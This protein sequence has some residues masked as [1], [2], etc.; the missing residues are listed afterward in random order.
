M[1]SKRVM[2]LVLVVPLAVGLVA[3]GKSKKS[4]SASSSAGAMSVSL[5]AKDFEFAPTALDVK[6]GQKV[7]VTFKNDGQAEHNFSITSLKVNQDLEAGK[8]ATVTFTAPDKA[9]DVEYFCEYHKASHNMV[10]TLH[11]T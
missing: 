11:V 5:T 6:A 9:G 2:A 1:L 7:T 4:S 10:G 8:T 3:C